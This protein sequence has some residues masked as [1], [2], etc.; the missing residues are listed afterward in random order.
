LV[1]DL[2]A[3]VGKS[4]GI[5]IVGLKVTLFLDCFLGRSHVDEKS[6]RRARV[7]DR[8]SCF[9]T[10]VDQHFEVVIFEGINCVLYTV[11][12]WY[13]WNWRAFA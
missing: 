7:P 9:H 13:I 3:L 11:F 10:F 5:F 12:F 6:L 8:N 1:P 2:I 4:S